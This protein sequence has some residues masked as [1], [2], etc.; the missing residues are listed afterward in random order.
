MKTNSK[1]LAMLLVSERDYPA[2]TLVNS[3]ETTGQIYFK[4]G[5]KH[6]CKVS[7]EFA[8]IIVIDPF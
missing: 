4:F 5:Q 6:S 2:S 8:V 7:F 3:S 1:P